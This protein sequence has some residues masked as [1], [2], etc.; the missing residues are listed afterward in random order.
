MSVTEM[1]AINIFFL[2]EAMPV[3][4]FCLLAVESSAAWPT[5]VMQSSSGK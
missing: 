2:D 5:D 1:Q 4:Q 3:T